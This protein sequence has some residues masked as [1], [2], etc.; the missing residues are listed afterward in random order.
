MANFT[1]GLKDSGKT[2]LGAVLEASQYDVSDIS[3]GHVVFASTL[4]GNNG[5]SLVIC[6]GQV[7]STSASTAITYPVTYY[8]K[9][10][11]VACAAD[12]GHSNAAETCGLDNIT[13]TGCDVISYQ[14]ASGA[15]VGQINW[16]SIGTANSAI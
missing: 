9:P 6:W 3:G 7:T 14:G 16:I 5:R 12:A 10:T 13:E 11:V 8:H 2:I 4:P 1:P 15:S